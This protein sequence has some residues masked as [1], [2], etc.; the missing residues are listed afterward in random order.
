K[1]KLSSRP[2]PQLFN[3]TKCVQDELIRH[4][5]EHIFSYKSWR[6]EYGLQVKVF[7]S[8]SLGPARDIPLSICRLF[9]DAK[10]IAGAGHLI[11]M[12]SMP[13]PSFWKFEPGEKVIIH[14]DDCTRFGTLVSSQKNLRSVLVCEVDIGSETLSVPIRDLEKEILLGQYVE[15]VGG[16]HLGKKGFVVGKSDTLL[17]ICINQ[18]TNGLDFRVHA[19]AVKIAVPDFSRTKTPWLNVEVIVESGP[20]RG[21]SGFVKDVVVNSTRSLAIT[22][23]LPNEQ[24]C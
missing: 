6:F 1:R 23:C 12:S 19:N 7:N 14:S 20:N 15:V 21:L 13:V 11:E 17:G 10:A 2:P 9:M 8:I 18:E 22:V 24:E 3:P 16:V 5:Q 4:K